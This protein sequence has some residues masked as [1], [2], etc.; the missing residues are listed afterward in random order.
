MG[1]HKGAEASGASIGTGKRRSKSEEQ[2]WSQGGPRGCTGGGSVE[3]DH[4]STD[5]WRKIRV[6]G[7][8]HCR[9]TGAMPARVGLGNKRGNGEETGD[10]KKKIE[11]LTRPDSSRA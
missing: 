1:L 5:R 6:G 9:V 8:R 7:Q 4:A 2:N 10:G 3:C 11:N